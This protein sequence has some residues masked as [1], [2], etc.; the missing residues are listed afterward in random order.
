MHATAPMRRFGAAAG[1]DLEG[2]PRPCSSPF[3]E[4]CGTRGLTRGLRKTRAA[5]A[6][7][8]DHFN[9][10]LEVQFITVTRRPSDLPYTTTA[11]DVA[12]FK[13]AVKVLDAEVRYAGALGVVWVFETKLKESAPDTWELCH[14][15][16]ADGPCPLCGTRGGGCVPAGHLHAH[17][18]VVLRRGTFIPWQWFARLESPRAMDPG[19]GVIKV[20]RSK[21][22]RDRGASVDKLWGYVGGYVQK[23]K[24][25][26]GRAWLRRM[27]GLNTRFMT[28]TGALRGAASLA[29]DVDTESRPD[30]QYHRV[31]RHF[32]V[33]DRLTAEVCQT[34]DRRRARVGASARDAARALRERGVESSSDGEWCDDLEW[35]EDWRLE[36]ATNRERARASRVGPTRAPP[37]E[38]PCTGARRP[39]WSAQPRAP[40]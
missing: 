39:Q 7:L 27:G 23:L 31:Q 20:D 13:A 32:R 34:A 25:P 37:T 17:G 14:E 24:E 26:M 29:T 3:C 40:S 38:R 35:L 15:G 33:R 1:W 5:F 36:D 2:A 10:R 11:E 21:R 6:R 18:I 28:A 4:T 30:L 22:T 8:Y 9:G 16:E 12:R 19:L